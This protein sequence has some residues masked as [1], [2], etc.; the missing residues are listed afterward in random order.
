MKARSKV[1]YLQRPSERALLLMTA[2]LGA[3]SSD[4]TSEPDPTQMPPGGSGTNSTVNAASPSGVN[5]APPASNPVMDGPAPMGST[6]ASEDN[7]GGNVDTSMLN[8]PT[9]SSGSS[10]STGG[11]GGGPADGVGGS[12]PEEPALDCSSPALAAGDSTRT[13]NVGG[14]NHTYILHVPNTYT[15]NEPVPLLF[16]FHGLGGNG[17]NQ[18]NGSSFVAA[19]ESEAVIMA[20]P[21]GTNDGSGGV[22]GNG[23]N[24]GETC[25]AL[26][27]D[28]ALTRAMVAEIQSLACIDSKRIYATGFSNGGGLSYKLAC[29]A[30]DIIAAVAPASFDLS[31]DNADDCQPSRPISTVAQRGT[32]D[33]AVP[34]E[35][36]LT[37]VN[38]LTV[39]LGARA[40]FEKWNELNGCT[41]P[42]VDVG[43]NCV[44][45]SQCDGGVEN[46]LCVIEGGGHQPG[47]ADL[48]WPLLRQ[49]TLP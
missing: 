3:C 34:F 20:F 19:T 6:P 48:L 36:G 45:V 35:G 13:I 22:P 1:K 15:G 41:G 29:D 46:T 24:V 7:A 14:T 49:Y 30:A 32:N 38:N 8:E 43:N 10:G 31:E 16:D 21:T 33:F 4:A 11:A 18:R 39:F 5:G 37:P 17:Q 47:N 40:N 2:L 23:W 44:K 28:V 9:S 25:C 27:D 12:V 26:G 42:E